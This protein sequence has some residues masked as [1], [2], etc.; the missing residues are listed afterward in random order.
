M[1]FSIWPIPMQQW[2]DVI[3]IAR[4]AEE[5]GW[6]GVYV[7]DHFM[8]DAGRW[9]PVETPMLEATAALSALAA[10]TDRVR[11]GSL[12][13]GVT[14][15]HPAVLANWAVTTDHVS[16]GRL[17]LGIGAGWQENEHEQ[18]GIPLGSR[19]ERLERFDEACQVLLGLLRT[20]RTT[21]LGRHYQVRDAVCEPKP[22]QDPLPVLVGGSGDRM[23]GVVARYA[24]EWNMWGLPRR[25]ASADRCSTSAA[26][27]SAVTRRPSPPPAKRCGSS[28]TT[29]PRPTASSPGRCARR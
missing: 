29:P 25:S 12:V 1:R 7:A 18:Y 5:T 8:G 26:K 3:E 24:D 17:L 4:H 22:Q 13:L 23:L 28:P 19:R 6:D 14:Y 9:G 20:P 27:R 2:S 11:L 15:R 16:G 21:V 10:A